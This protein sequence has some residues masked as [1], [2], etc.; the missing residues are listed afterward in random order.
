[1]VFLTL[2]VAK[3][4]VIRMTYKRDLGEVLNTEK[5]GKHGIV[6]EEINYDKNTGQV[7]VDKEIWRANSEDNKTIKEGIHIKVT[8][9][10]GTH[11]TVKE[12][13]NCCK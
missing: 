4:E 8:N 13:E 1:M 9:I 6:V 2:L 12:V 5:I 7:R 10:N 11:M 3:E